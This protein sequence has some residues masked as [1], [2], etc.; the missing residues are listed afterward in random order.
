MESRFVLHKSLYLDLACF[1]P[2]RFKPQESLPPNALKKI[3]ALVN[4][5]GGKLREELISFLNVWPPISNASIDYEDKDVSEDD[6]DKMQCTASALCHNC[7]KCA[8]KLI[9]PCKILERILNQRIKKLLLD[10]P[11]LDN[12]HMGFIPFKDCQSIHAK[13][14]QENK[15]AHRDREHIVCISPD[16]KSTL[17]RISPQGNT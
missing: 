7:I 13:I 3:E 17:R 9:F 14:Y 8:Y 6:E 5:N 1:D 10:H 15:A 11:I 16:I 12:N 2:K 4:V